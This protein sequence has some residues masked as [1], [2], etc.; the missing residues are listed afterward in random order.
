MPKTARLSTLCMPYMYPSGHVILGEY[1]LKGLL[2]ACSIVVFYYLIKRVYH[3]HEWSLADRAHEWSLADRAFTSGKLPSTVWAELQ[4][5]I[6]RGAR[7]RGVQLR[8]CHTYHLNPPNTILDKYKK[9]IGKMK[10]PNEQQLYHGTR[11]FDAVLSI[12]NGGFR[13]PPKTKSNMFGP[14]V[15]FATVPQKSY[16]YTGSGGWILIC[17]VAVGDSLKVKKATFI[18]PDKDLRARSCIF[19]TKTYE[20]VLAPAGNSTKSDEYVVYVVDKICPVYLISVE[21]V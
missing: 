3:A 19:W 11:S 8:V 7:E 2:C 12:A 18:D 17:N 9:A 1:L 15:Y 6:A 13:L 5:D 4:A 16:D 20:S 14:G 21:R 10:K